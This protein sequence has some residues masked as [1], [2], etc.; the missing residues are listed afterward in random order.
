MSL[1]LTEGKIVLAKTEK[2]IMLFGFLSCW[3]EYITGFT[4]KFM[5]R[6]TVV[7]FFVDPV[8]LLNLQ[9]NKDGGYQFYLVFYSSLFIYEKKLTCLYLLTSTVRSPNLSIG[10]FDNMLWMTKIVLVNS[11]A[12]LK[13]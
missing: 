12:I 3:Y 10:I 6:K 8:P 13:A 9:I 7:V 4:Y 2:L 1:L 11:S 5:E